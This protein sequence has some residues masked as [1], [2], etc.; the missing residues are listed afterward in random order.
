VKLPFFSKKQSN[1]TG[2]EVKTARAIVFM[3]PQRVETCDVT[4]PAMGPWDVAIDVGTSAISAGTERWALMGRRHDV[5]FPAIPGYLSVGQIAAVGSQVK[6]FALGDRVNFFSAKMPQNFEGNWMC[7]HVA[8]AICSVEPSPHVE[9]T[10]IPYVV[11]VPKDV[12]DE[13]AVW[14]ALAAVSKRGLDMA[15]IKA[16]EKVAV[17]GLGIVGQMCVQLAKAAGARVFATDL[18][19]SRVK[20]AMELGADACSVSGL[21]LSENPIRQFALEGYSAV[22]DTTANEKVLNSLAGFLKPG[23]RVVMQ[24][25]YPDPL[26]LDLREFHNKAVSVYFPCAL[27]KRD[28]ISAMALMATGKLR[29]SALISHR[30]K[31]A[32]AD[33][34]YKMVLSDKAGSLGHVFAWQ[35]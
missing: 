32:Q 11:P 28:V 21:E 20:K 3:G 16:D 31:P 29:A 17:F 2:P 23:G 24:A 25:W 6:N 5:K 15:K 9:E 26:R 12:A 30:W 35:S 18:D 4:L 27:H 7:G 13:D 8:R 33:E 10:G 14:A 34:A 19:E 1:A 22:V